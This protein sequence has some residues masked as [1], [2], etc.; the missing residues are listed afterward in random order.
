MIVFVAFAIFCENSLSLCVF[1][2][3]RE[4]LSV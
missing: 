3:L 1:A 4:I 2:P